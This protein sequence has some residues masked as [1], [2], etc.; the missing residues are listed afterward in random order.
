MS[1][2]YLQLTLNDQSKDLLTV[3]THKELFTYNRQPFGVSSALGIFQCFLLNY[4]T[5]PQSTTGIPPSQLLMGRHLRTHLHQVIP[6]LAKHVQHTQ[7]TQKHFYDQYTIDCNFAS[8][9]RVLVHNYTGSPYWLPGIIKT[10]L[11]PVSN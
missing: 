8:E 3:N 6:D 5:T 1:Q 2:A 7:F 11:G 4:R 9:Q 10:V